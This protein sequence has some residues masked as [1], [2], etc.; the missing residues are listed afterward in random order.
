MRYGI[1][2]LGENKFAKVTYITVVERQT[3]D[4]PNAHIY[5]AILDVVF[6]CTDNR[7]GILAASNS[8][9]TEIALNM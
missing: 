1:K 4:D 8:D 6:D 7:L 3:D 5:I 9:P 2:A